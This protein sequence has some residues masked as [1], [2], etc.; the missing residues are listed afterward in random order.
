MLENMEQCWFS[1]DFERQTMENSGDGASFPMVVC[2]GT[3]RKGSL[4][5]S[6]VDIQRKVLKLTSLS[7]SPFTKMDGIFL[8]GSLRFG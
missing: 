4:T 8:P 1:G 7:R 5:G 3:R 6:A 2:E